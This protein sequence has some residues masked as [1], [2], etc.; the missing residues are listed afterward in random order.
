MKNNSLKVSPARRVYKPKYPSHNEKN[1]LFYPE[2]RPYPFKLKFLK[3]VSTGGLAGAMILGGDQLNGQASN[4]NLYN[5]FTLE[6]SGLPYVPVM[7]GTG[8]P[9]RIRSHEAIGII[10]KA[11]AES[12]LRLE[13]NMWYEEGDLDLYL[14]GYSCEEEI[15]F[16]FLDYQNMDDTFQDSRT[17]FLNDSETSSFKDIK[18]NFEE[19]KKRFAKWAT[20]DFDRFLTDKE[21]FIESKIRYKPDGI[22][23]VYVDELNE[24]ETLKKHKKKFA[25]ARLNHQLQKHRQEV[26]IKQNLASEMTKHIDNRLDDSI[27]K[28][29]L[30]NRTSIRFPSHHK[31]AFENIVSKTFNQLTNILSDDEFIEQFLKLRAFCMYDSGMSSLARN[32]EYVSQKLEIMQK[33]KLSKWFDQVEKLDIIKDEKYVSFE[34]AKVIDRENKMH[35][36]FVAPISSEDE[37]MVIQEESIPYPDDLELE[38]ELLEEAYN[39]ANGM[40]PEILQEKQSSLNAIYEK[41]DLEK[42]DGLSD[43]KKSEMQRKLW[44][45]QETINLKYSVMGNLTSEEKREWRDKFYEVH[46]KKQ[47]WYRANQDLVRMETLR[48]LESKV[49]MYIEW[50]RAQQGY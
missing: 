18:Q 49:K 10:K 15:G 46:K 44:N 29:V 11:F 6:K 24:I 40:T 28:M 23:Y 33:S 45:E 41:Y 35:E 37:M 50:A 38:Q 22:D 1:P 17:R 34:E 4:K 14:T 2:T 7:F 12:G 8:L 32:P 26:E 9:D 48:Q 20:S 43:E 19:A 39:L 36:H 25:A 3:W 31:Q 5:P 16:L 27:E 30:L 21:A 13:E 47:E 42:H